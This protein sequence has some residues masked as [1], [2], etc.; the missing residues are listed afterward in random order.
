LAGSVR[1]RSIAPARAL[2]AALVS[3]ASSRR[4]ALRRRTWAPSKIARGTRYR[5]ATN[6]KVV[7]RA[8]P[9]GPAPGG[10]SARSTPAND[11]TVGSLG[12]AG[13]DESTGR[14]PTT[15][16]APTTAPPLTDSAIGS[17]WM[18]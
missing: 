17:V 10:D 13:A 8:S 2:S 9:P 5:N 15:S 4:A 18:V 6:A 7:E 12:A 11:D 3:P 16:A 14:A 1:A